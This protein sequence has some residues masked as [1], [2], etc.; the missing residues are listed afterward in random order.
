MSNEDGRSTVPKFDDL[1][2]LENGNS[3]LF[4]DWSLKRIRLLE[5]LIIMFSDFLV[6]L[7]VKI[8]LL[9]YVIIKLIGKIFYN[10]LTCDF[11][12]PF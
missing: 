7:L 3:A 1:T 10:Y 6:D 2:K 8:N 11:L 12:N 5:I 4:P 9:H